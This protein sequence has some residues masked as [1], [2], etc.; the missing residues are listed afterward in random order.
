VVIIL[1]MFHYRDTVICS[2]M[3]CEWLLH[4]SC[5]VTVIQLYVAHYFVIGYYSVLFVT[6]MQ[7]YIAN[8]SLPSHKEN[9]CLCSASVTLSLTAS[10]PSWFDSER[11]SHHAIFEENFDF[12]LI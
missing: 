1:F 7:L 12:S 2:P 4:C 11:P 3:L 9:I 10:H 8:D 5:V 6:N